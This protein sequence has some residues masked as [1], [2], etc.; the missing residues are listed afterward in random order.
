MK[1]A[2]WCKMDEDLSVDGAI[3]NTIDDAVQQVTAPLSDYIS[4][5]VLKIISVLVIL[6]AG[7]IILT[8][9]LHIVQKALDHSRFDDVLHTF[10][11]SSIKVVFS[12]MLVLTVLGYLGIPMTP[13]ITMMGA[14]GV[15][16]ALALKDSLGNFAGGILIIFNQ[17]FKKGDFIE[18]A[19]VTG[20]VQEINLIYSTLTTPNRVI[21]MPNG[22]LANQTVINFSEDENRRVDCQFGIS[23]DSDIDK[24]KEIITNVIDGSDYFNTGRK[25][26]VGVSAHGDSAVMIDALAWC[27]NDDY[28][29]AKYYLLETVKKEFDKAGIDIPYPQIT[30]HSS[31][32]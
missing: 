25:A 28:Y 26:S 21:S 8:V 2:K 29:A 20:R 3:E 12:V 18:C 17:P 19:G 13:F 15:A 1:K 6:I 32:H 4:G 11:I 23:Y 27:S 10:V 14:C 16:V 31:D 5:P 30:V 7:L 9:L 24:A 22:I